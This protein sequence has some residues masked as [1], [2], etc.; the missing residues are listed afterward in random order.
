MRCGAGRGE[1]EEH[2]VGAAS[3]TLGVVL[4]LRADGGS[5]RSVF[6][7]LLGVT[8]A[9]W[10]SLNVCVFLFVGGNQCFAL[11]LR[12]WRA[13]MSVMRGKL[14]LSAWLVTR[15]LGFCGWF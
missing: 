8:R 5:A 12:V 13:S 9:R 14:A 11:M 6:W 10:C 3:L 15:G 7:A 4:G 2:G 1:S